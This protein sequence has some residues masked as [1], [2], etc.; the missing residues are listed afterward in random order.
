[1]STMRENRKAF[2]FSAIEYKDEG[3][4]TEADLLD[5]AEHC[6]FRLGHVSLGGV[7]IQAT[8]RRTKLLNQSEE[9]C[10]GS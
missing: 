1:M 7:I 5:I 10:H 3:A 4:L 2:I 9:N 6:I 8:A